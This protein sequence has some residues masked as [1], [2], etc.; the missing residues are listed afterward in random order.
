MCGKR[1]FNCARCDKIFTTIKSLLDH[2]RAA[3]P[4]PEKRKADDNIPSTSTDTTRKQQK[5]GS[6]SEP[7][8]RTDKEVGN[9]DDS[10][11]CGKCQ[12]TFTKI[13]NRKRH[14]KTCGGTAENWPCSTCGKFFSRKDARTRHERTCKYQFAC[15]KCTTTFNGKKKRDSHEKNCGQ[16]QFECARC[17]ETFT[18]VKQLQEHR[19][20]AHPPQKD[21]N[22][23]KK[24]KVAVTTTSTGDKK[25]KME[26]SYTCSICKEQHNSMTLLY[27]HRL[28][29]HGQGTDLQPRPWEEEAAPW[30]VDNTL[31]GMQDEYD[32]NAPHILR[33]GGEGAIRVEYNF[34]TSDIRGGTNELMGH[35]RSIFQREKHAFKLNISIGYMLQNIDSN[36]YRYFIP[37]NNSTLFDNNLSIS[38]IRDLENVREQL[39]DLNIV[40]HVHKQRPNTAWKMRMVTNVVFYI[41]RTSFPLGRGDLPDY[42]KRKKSIIGLVR[43]IHHKSNFYN[44]NLC[45]FRCL[46]LHHKQTR[47]ETA[48][49]IYYERWRIYMLQYDK[50]LPGDATEYEGI[51]LS[52]LSHFEKCF[53]IQATVCELREDGTV[54]VRHHPTTKF[55]EKIYMNLFEQHLSYITKFTAYAKKIQCPVCD[56]HFK[57]LADIKRHMKIC[58]NITKYKLPGG[59]FQGEQSIFEKMEEFG[60]VYSKEEQFFPWFAVFDFEAILEKIHENNSPKLTWTAKHC[61]ISVSICSNVENY[62]TAK[63][64]VNDDLATLLTK[65][66]NHLSEISSQAEQMAR[67]KWKHAI[68][69]LEKLVREWK[70]EVSTSYF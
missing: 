11:K 66:I 67:E 31:H 59:M 51:Q 35:L 60:I 47:I 13:T 16:N 65:M 8:I 55:Q 20:T 25:T 1:H 58:S 56:R 62:N 33:S 38:S 43:N 2:R 29:Q 5:K 37:Y 61:P 23:P 36:T 4:N 42:I 22:L 32:T 48:I 26:K 68:Q 19:R 69:E 28:N 49:R 10:L 46:A 18:S 45:A 27:R 30:H 21:Q 12:K 6:E 24:R 64:F 14:E 50:N 40:Q 39:Q 57:R 41:Y 70:P 9:Q 15:S 7:D 3:H 63:C 17:D 34:P 52:E 44:D 54:I 53:Q